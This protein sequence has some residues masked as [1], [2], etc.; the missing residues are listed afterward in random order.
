MPNSFFAKSFISSNE[1]SQKIEEK[2]GSKTYIVVQIPNGG[3]YAG[4]LPNEHIQY[5]GNI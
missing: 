1:I 3:N 2:F 5:F 4:Y